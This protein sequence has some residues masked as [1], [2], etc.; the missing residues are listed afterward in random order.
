MSEGPEGGAHGP[1][2]EG[3]DHSLLLAHFQVGGRVASR[4]QRNFEICASVK[5]QA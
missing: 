3:S 1:D 5:S 2:G 4:D